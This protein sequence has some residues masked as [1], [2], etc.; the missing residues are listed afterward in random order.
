MSPVPKI[1]AM[2]RILA[3]LIAL[4]ILSVGFG[5]LQ[6]FWPQVKGQSFVRR[7]GIFVDVTWWL[8]T[9]TIGKLFTGI[10][11]GGSLLALAAV[12]P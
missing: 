7:Q 4:A 8:F 11:V 6:R 1:A 3:L 12:V 2:E 5:V 9:P 10:V